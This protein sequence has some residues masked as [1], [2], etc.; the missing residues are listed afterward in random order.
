[1]FEGLLYVRHKMGGV[2]SVCGPYKM[3]GVMSVCGLYKMGGV[4]S[5]WSVQDGWGDECVVRTR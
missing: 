3:G 2:M 1:M 4:M 5:V